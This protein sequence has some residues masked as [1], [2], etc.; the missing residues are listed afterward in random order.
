MEY[1]CSKYC[2]K[3][4]WEYGEEGA[5]FLPTEELYYSLM[6]TEGRK[7]LSSSAQNMQDVLSTFE[8]T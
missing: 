5:Q 7:D 4:F 8:D 6:S 1:L 3:Q 2:V